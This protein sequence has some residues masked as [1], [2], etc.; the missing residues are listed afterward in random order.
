MA[1]SRAVEDQRCQVSDLREGCGWESH[2]SIFEEHGL[3]AQVA[4]PSHAGPVQVLLLP[5][6]GDR[7]GRRSADT[8]RHRVW[9]DAP[10]TSQKVWHAVHSLQAAQR[11]RWTTVAPFLACLT[12]ALRSSPRS[13]VAGPRAARRA[14]SRTVAPAQVVQR[15]LHC[16][17]TEDTASVPRYGSL[18]R[19]AASPVVPV[20]AGQHRTAADP[21]IGDALVIVVA[22]LGLPDARS[23]SH[24]PQM[25]PEGVHHQ[26]RR[27]LAPAGA[28]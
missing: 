8:L 17:V 1:E 14:G 5:R 19:R 13:P 24:Q 16:W 25:T 9:A 2:H 11:L 28:G 18:P 6:P 10:R 12:A 23:F 7:P 15:R 22:V 20:D 26:C 3:R 4:S 21:G 27:S